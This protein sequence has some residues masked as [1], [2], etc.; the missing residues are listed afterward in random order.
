[1]LKNLEF[2]AEYSRINPWVYTH[3]IT[4]TEFTNNGYIM[5]SWMG[6]NADN[7]C[8]DLS[9]RPVRSV[10]FGGTLQVFRKGGLKDISF[11]YQ[12]PSQPFLYGPL[13][14]ERSIGFHARYQ[15]VRDGFIDARI[16][17]RTTSDEALHLSNDRKVEFSVSAR[18]GL[19]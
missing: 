7:L 16:T 17:S 9:Y 15:F 13:H 2:T 18:Y 10:R 8:F 3:R 5:G 19:W 11:Q 12:Y 14:E 1:L 4:A 6:Q